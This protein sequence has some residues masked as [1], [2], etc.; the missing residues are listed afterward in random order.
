[1]KIME[2]RM[3]KGK[4]F[5]RGSKNIW[6]EYKETKGGVWL[7]GIFF[8]WSFIMSAI[9]FLSEE[10]YLGTLFLMGFIY[11]GFCFVIDT[12]EENHF[13]QR[14]IQEKQMEEQ[15]G[16]IQKKNKRR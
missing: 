6:E 13:A 11:S 8:L 3:G 16:T 7:W 1:M 4:I 12:I 14:Y 15:N 5:L 10:F 9:Y 2:V